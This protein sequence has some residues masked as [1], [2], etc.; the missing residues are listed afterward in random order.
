MTKQHVTVA[1]SGDGG[2]ELFAGYNRYG[3]GLRVARM[4]RLLPRPVAMALARSL[5]AVP[6]AKWDR[7]FD[8]IPSRFRLRL[9]GDKLQKLADVLGDDVTGYYLSLIHI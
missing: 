7:L 1:L 8:I 5:R 9:P 2:D 6:P 4:L 3:Q